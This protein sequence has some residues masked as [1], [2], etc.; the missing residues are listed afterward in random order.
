M[1]EFIEFVTSQLVDN[2]E[3][4]AVHDESDSQTVR[5]RIEL[6]SEDVG[7]VIGRGGHTIGAVRSLLAAAAGREGKRAFVEVI[8]KY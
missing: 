1:K 7:K 6:L 3:T 2:P 4:V 8:E 5:F